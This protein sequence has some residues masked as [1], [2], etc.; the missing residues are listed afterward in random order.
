MRIRTWRVGLA[1]L[2]GILGTQQVAADVPQVATDIAPVHSLVSI[3][4]AGVG[5]PDLV[6]PPGISPHSHS[7]RPSE[8]RALSEADLIVWVGSELTPWL[9]RSLDNLGGSSTHLRLLEVDGITRLN[10]RE[11]GIFDQT[12]HDADHDDH[13]HHDDH[14]GHDDHA[15]HESHHHDD[16]EGHDDHAH[17][18]DHGDHAHHDDHDTEHH[19][20][21]TDHDNHDD[22]AHHDDHHHDHDGVDPHA[23]LSP[24]NAAIWVAR[25]AE[26]LSTLDPDNADTYRANAETAQADLM[27][28]DAEIAQRI[29]ALEGA[30][31]VFHDAYQYFETRYDVQTAG[32]IALGDGVAPGPARL[33]AIRDAVR[34]LSVNCV[35]TEPQFNPGLAQTVVEGTDATIGLIDPLGA[36]FTPGPTLY[37]DLLRGMAQSFE[38]CLE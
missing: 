18:D 29:A 11:G 37:P 34:E 14:E 26:E 8:A 4:M 2:V 5:T 12:M 17:E 3:V 21:G 23:W 1:A 6:L 36:T 15:D 27:A 35:L 19:D 7:L 25:I 30:F 31:V 32:A 28:L 13:A 10:F 24:Q 16:H 33:A 20:D 38:E 22:H 9:E